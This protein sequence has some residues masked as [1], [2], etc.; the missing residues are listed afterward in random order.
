MTGSPNERIAYR[1]R[2]VVEMTGISRATVFRHIASG[3]LKTIKIGSITLVRH[4]D[5]QAFIDGAEPHD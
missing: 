2:E 3:R 1:I 4:A 5:L